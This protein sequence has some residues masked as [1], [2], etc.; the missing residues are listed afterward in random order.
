MRATLNDNAREAFQ[1]L[2]IGAGLV[3]VGRGLYWA[4][5][6]WWQDGDPTALARAAG[7]FQDG[8][9]VG[10]DTMV[11]GGA[12]IGGRLAL[13]AVMALACGGLLA[14]AGG[15]MARLARRSPLHVA[16]RWARAGLLIAGMWGM[17]A[18]LFL[19]PR[20]T[21]WTEE[22]PVLRE[23]PALLGELSLPWPARD[24]ILPWRSIGSIHARS[25]ASSFQGCGTMEQV[26]ATSP[27]GDHVLAAIA[28]AG[29][30]CESARG[31]AAANAHALAALLETERIARTY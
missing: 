24:L 12:G 2:M 11:A 21:R 19:P 22:G 10:N 17:Y 23:R 3:L 13:A 1:F 20:S 7:I 5:G 9:L 29:S 8:Y 4:A 27:D 28:P 16:V 31:D 14:L 18:A 26:I 15:G 30:D 25:I 6:R